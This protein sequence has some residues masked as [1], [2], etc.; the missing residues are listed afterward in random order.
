MAIEIISVFV[1]ISPVFF[2]LSEGIFQLIWKDPLTVSLLIRAKL[3]HGSKKFHYKQSGGYSPL[4]DLYV[5]NDQ[6]HTDNI[7]LESPSEAG[8]LQR[9]YDDVDENGD[10]ELTIVELCVFLN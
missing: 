10:E 3:S 5:S 7:E 6:S 1:N 8:S 9:I 4:S 2:T